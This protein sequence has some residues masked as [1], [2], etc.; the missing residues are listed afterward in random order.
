MKRIGWRFLYLATIFVVLFS[1]VVSAEAIQSSVSQTQASSAKGERAIEQDREKAIFEAIQSVNPSTKKGEAQ[2]AVEGKNVGVEIS[3]KDR[4]AQE[5]ELLRLARQEQFKHLTWGQIK[6]TITPKTVAEKEEFLEAREKKLDA[7]VSR[8]VSIS[9]Q[10]DISKQRINLARF[11]IAKAI[12]DFFPEATFEADLKHGS[13]S[14]PAFVSDHWRTK[15][16][17]PVFRGGVL[18]NTL[19]L[20][21]NNLEVAKRD[22]DKTVSNL[23]AA[24]SQAYFEY[25]RAQ[26]ILR[27]QEELIQKV[28]EQ[29]RISDEKYKSKLTSEIEKL[30]TDS[31]F[32]QAQYDL[33]TTQQEVEIA[34]LELQKYLNLETTDPIEISPL[35][36]LSELNV[37]A[38]R[39][40]PMI[41]GS[42]VDGKS[43]TNWEHLIEL[44]YENRPDLQVESAK[45]KATQFAYRVALGQRLPQFDLL[46]EFGELAES[47]ISDSLHPKHRPE[48]RFGME[49]TW[50]F[51]GNTLKYALDHDQHAKSVTQFQSGEGTRTFSHTFSAKLLDDMG[52]FSSMLEAKVNNLEQVVELEKTERDVVREVKEAY[53]NFNKALIQVES[54]YKRMGYRNRLAQLAKHRLDTNEIQIS[55]Y[56]QAEMDFTQERGLVY[57]AL[58]ELFLSKAK[59]NRAIGIRNYLPVEVLQ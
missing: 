12:R 13:L 54:A 50:P 11:R 34:K 56:L 2:G 52:Q 25:E 19:Q 20:E 58:S 32:G 41:P 10:A 27:D 51:L 29:K 4:I 17:I 38:L 7:V 55:E 45:L 59:L 37:E 23:I 33:E 31:L 39:K 3:Q 14:V 53:F 16:R 24:V 18:W 35:Y 15:L 9:V 6:R 22:Y 26:N 40:T 48:F 43:S 30:N 21:M 49:A 57:K 36:S 5:V 47:F 44:A 8:A 1:R 46:V 42:A 28:E